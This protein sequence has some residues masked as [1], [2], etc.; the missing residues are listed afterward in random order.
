[1]EMRSHLAR[2]RG[3]GSTNEGVHHWRWQRISGVALL[4]LALWFVFSTIGL[5]GADLVT[6]RTWVGAYG[7]PVLLTL[8]TITMFHHAQL[9]LQVVIED[10]VQGETAKTSSLFVIKA[11]AVLC[12]ASCIFAI[13]RLTFEG[14]A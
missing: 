5:V 1:M 13:I 8:L 9:G 11:I 14:Y 7:N 2:A 12:G 3:L 10:Y 4:P 6:V